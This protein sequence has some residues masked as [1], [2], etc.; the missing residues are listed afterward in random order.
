MECE[1]VLERNYDGCGQLA[2]YVDGYYHSIHS[3]LS[4]AEAEVERLQ[5]EEEE[6]E[7]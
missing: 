3:S 7:K 1:I 4:D 2:V 5:S 6:A